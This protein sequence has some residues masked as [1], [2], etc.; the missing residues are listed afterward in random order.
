MDNSSSMNASRWWTVQRG[1]G[2]VVATA[3]HDGTDLREE[4]AAAMKLSVPDRF[5]EEDPFTGQ[6]VAGVPTHV[7]VH[8]SR[9]EFDLNRG[10]ED[11]IY[12]T[13]E[14]SWGLDVWHEPPAPQLVERSLALHAAYYAMLGDLLDAV[15]REHERFVVLDVHSYNHRRNGPE[16]APTPQHQAPDINIGTFS[17]PR[18]QWAGLLDP[19]MEAM[20]GFDFNGRR[21]D[22]R[23][24]IAFQGKGEQTRFIHQRYPGRA[25]AIALEFKKF[26]MD[27][28][29]GEP[30]PAEL[31][32]MRRFIT[33]SAATA[34]RLLR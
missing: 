21:L 14:Q 4:V 19:L 34:E 2:P 16:A 15:A 5:R 11:A 6:A 29:S 32:A 10:A 28:W 12:Q 31:D 27:E 30:D 25:C 23:E 22:V 24:N 33:F 7:I 26:Y 17:T 8:R 13:P 3:I 1:A 18:E 9:F 20:R